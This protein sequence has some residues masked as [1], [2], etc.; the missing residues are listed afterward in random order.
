VRHPGASDADWIA[1]LHES[2]AARDEDLFS[3]VFADAAV[4]VVDE[5]AKEELWALVLGFD[6]GLGLFGRGIFDGEFGKDGAIHTLLI[7]AV[8]PTNGSPSIMML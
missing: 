8:L 6:Q 4:V 3:V 5:V 2:D 7:R 1:D